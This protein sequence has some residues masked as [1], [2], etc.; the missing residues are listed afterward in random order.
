M[1]FISFGH[2]EDLELFVRKML[3]LKGEHAYVSE[4]CVFFFRSAAVDDKNAI[5][6]NVG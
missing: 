5:I 1:S 4:F 3:M 6:K 2:F